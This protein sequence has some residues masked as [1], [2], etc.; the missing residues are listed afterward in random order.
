M[1]KRG[2]EQMKNSHTVIT[3][4]LAIIVGG[5]SFFA[6]VLYQKSHSQMG[7]QGYLM[8]TTARSGRGQ[9]MFGSRGRGNAT[10]GK[11]ISQD[12][13]SLTVQLADGSTKIILVSGS[14]VFAKNDP[15]ISSDIK[16]G[17]R[18]MVFGSVN[19]DGSLTAQNV[20]INPPQRPV[21]T[22]TATQ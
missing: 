21:A 4:L 5:I 11:V 15:A 2:G 14:T 9:T 6:G 19:S 1:S 17:D 7:N 20:Q 8:E 13:T 3:I 22:P 16:I 18:I 12:A 10:L